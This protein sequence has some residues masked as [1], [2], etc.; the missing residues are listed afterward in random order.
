MLVGHGSPQTCQVFIYSSADYL[1]YISPDDLLLTGNEQ[2]P[3]IRK[4]NRIKAGELFSKRDEV[5]E[6]TQFLQ[7]LG[8]PLIQSLAGTA[9]D[10]KGLRVIDIMRRPGLVSL[11]KPGLCSCLCRCGRIFEGFQPG[12]R[13]Q[14][15]MVICHTVFLELLLSQRRR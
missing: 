11:W 9:Q 13:V 4:R 5:L 6:E 1:F 14:I 8:F 7:T 10:F 3:L 12:D 2:F 15:I